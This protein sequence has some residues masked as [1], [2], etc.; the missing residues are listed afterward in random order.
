MMR[1][2]RLTPL[3]L[4]LL[5]ACAANDRPGRGEGPAGMQR[6]GFAQAARLVDAGRYEEALPIL[7]CVAR[8]GEGFEIA[9]YLAGYSALQLAEAGDTPDIL[10]A[11]LRIE[12]FDR[13][14]AAAEAGWPAAQAR[15]AEEFAV[16]RG[17]D[18]QLQAAYWAEVYRNNARE[19][20]YGLD[21][22]DDDVEA[23]IT[24]ALDEDRLDDARMR[25]AGFSP[26]PLEGE[27][28]DAACAPYL[29]EAGPG[30]GGGMLRGRGGRGERSPGGGRPPGG[31]V[32]STELQTPA[33]DG[34]GSS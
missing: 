17:A 25:A 4:L 5:A 11:E 7:R 30:A 1:L 27:E 32:E 6:S 12:G 13:L 14:I 28:I 29:R 16:T 18:A 20:V 26:V 33:R 34:T 21:R 15:L 31:F 8:R 23:R 19:Q 3:T 24:A 9:Q 10:R 22:L 2:A